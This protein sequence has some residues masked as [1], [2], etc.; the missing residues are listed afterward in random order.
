MIEI[1]PAVPE[2]ASYLNKWLTDPSILRWFPMTD[3]REIDDA[4]RIWMSY[5]KYQACFTAY[6]DGVPV[7]M[8]TLYLQPYQKFAHQCLF[9]IIVDEKHRNQGIGKAL[10]ER[11]IE[12][13]KNQFNIEILHLEVYEGNPAI[14][15]YER[16]GFREFGRQPKFI[17]INGE[18]LDKIMMQKEL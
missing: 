13:A 18:Y 2:E 3:V 10:L 12:A 14:R 4:V 8:S 5:S 1:R 17:K 9:A 11:M 6:V 16:M 15:L 7:G